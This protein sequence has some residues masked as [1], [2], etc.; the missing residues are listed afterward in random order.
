VIM[1]WTREEDSEVGQVRWFEGWA[2]NAGG[3]GEMLK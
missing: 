1:R 3:E 2:R